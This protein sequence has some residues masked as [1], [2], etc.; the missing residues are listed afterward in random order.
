MLIMRIKTRV[1]NTAPDLDR[2]PKTPLNPGP[3]RD[4]DPQHCLYEA[5]IP[6]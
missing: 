1:R 5:V 2:D 3:I 4:P 6:V